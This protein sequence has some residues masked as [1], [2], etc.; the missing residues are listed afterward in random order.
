MSVQ[1][2]NDM[3]L[4]ETLL[5]PPLNKQAG[6]VSDILPG[7]MSRIKEYFGSKYSPE[8]P[9]ASVINDL[10]PGAIWTLFSTLGLGKWGILLGFLM[11]VLHIDAHGLLSSIYSEVK[12]LLSGGQKVSSDQIDSIVNSAVQEHSTEPTQNDIQEG[13]QQSQKYDHKVFS[14]IMQDVR[15]ISLGMQQYERQLFSL[16]KI[17]DFV[18]F[19]KTYRGKRSAGVGILGRIFGLIFK[20]ALRSAGLLVVGDIA[21][22]ILGRP[23]SIDG[24]YQEGQSGSSTNPAPD[25]SSPEPTP[26]AQQTKFPPNQDLPLPISVNQANS[27]ENIEALLIQFAKNCYSGLDGKEELITSDPIFQ[28]I[29]EK[30]VWYN[31][32]NAGYNT[33]FLPPYWKTQKQLV[34]TFI[35]SVA[36]RDTSA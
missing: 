27:P 13:Y 34:D 21:N 22:K 17:A 10:A 29:K 35:D 5:A 8:N 12:S 11:D 9:T 16:T 7:V 30:I 1:L 19:S 18:G 15:L 3:W 36:K 6:V 4:I 20:V 26:T 32:R 2:F 28:L 25:N 23:N 24:T 31:S 33:I 14:S